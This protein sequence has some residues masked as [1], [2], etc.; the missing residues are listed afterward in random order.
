MKRLELLGV[1]TLMFAMTVQPAI[2]SDTPIFDGVPWGAADAL[3]KQTLGAQGFVFVKQD[4]DGDLDFSGEISGQK[5]LIWEFMTPARKLVKAE[6]AFATDDD[7]A[8]SFFHEVAGTTTS[9]YGAPTKSFAFYKDPYSD[10]DSESDHETAFKVG[11]A[12]LANFWTFSDGGAVY[13]EVTKRLT[14][15]LNYESAA[16]EKELARRFPTRRPPLVMKSVA[17]SNEGA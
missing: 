11:K 8:I 3:V 4:A 2:A 15:D 10:A 16:W 17:Q 14:V 12:E 5:V 1:A 6:V 13:I 9:K 7:E